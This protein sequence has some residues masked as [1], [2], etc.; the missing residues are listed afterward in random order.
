[1]PKDRQRGLAHRSHTHV[2]VEVS[3]VTACYSS[4]QNTMLVSPM[5]V[6]PHLE[7]MPTLLC[8]RVSE[9]SICEHDG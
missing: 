7:L 9:Q 3:F 4:A 2:E 1:M 8:V 5:K 6:P